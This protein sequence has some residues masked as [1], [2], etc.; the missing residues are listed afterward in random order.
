[1]PDGNE[2]TAYMRDGVPLAGTMAMSEEIRAMN[3][4]SHWNVY[5]RHRPR[6]RIRRT[7]LSNS[8]L[9]RALWVS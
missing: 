7:H 5:F 4:P 3:I 8:R 9:T 2:Y 1:M 6:V